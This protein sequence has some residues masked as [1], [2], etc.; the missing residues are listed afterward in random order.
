[1][2][3]RYRHGSAICFQRKVMQ[4]VSLSHHLTSSYRAVSDRPAHYRC[5]CLEHHVHPVMNTAIGF[6]SPPSVSR[7]KGFKGLTKK[8]NGMSG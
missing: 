3:L 7:I 6:A 1:M 2:T 4:R 8:G 5:R